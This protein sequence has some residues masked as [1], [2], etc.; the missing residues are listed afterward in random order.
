MARLRRAIP[1]G[2]GTTPLPALR[3]GDLVAFPTETVHAR[4]QRDAAALRRI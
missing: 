4:R 1:F 3:N 2:T